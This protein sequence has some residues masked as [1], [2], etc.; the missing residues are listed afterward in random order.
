M[1]RSIRAAVTAAVMLIA[2][3]AVMAAPAGAAAPPFA[4]MDGVVRLIAPAGARAPLPAAHVVRT[5]P[6][7]SVAIDVPAARAA[8]AWSVLAGRHAPGT[9]LADVRHTWADHV[10]TDPLWSEMWGARRIRLPAAWPSSLGD[11]DVVIAVLDTGV[12]A[13]A[14]LDGALL[15]GTD[16]VDGDTDPSDAE[17]HGTVVAQV[18]AARIDNGVGGVGA[19]PACAVL[20]VRIGKKDGVWESDS[21]A[22]IVWAV[23]HGATVINM[24]YGSTGRVGLEEAAVRY[25]RSAGVTLVA[26][27]GNDGGTA[28]VYP[29]ALPGVIS[30]AATD[31]HDVVE[32][33]SQ[34]GAW[35]DVAAP[36]EA[37]TPV[38]DDT[39]LASSGT[40]FS[41]PLVAGLVALLTSAA[42]TATRAEI[43][44]AITSS[45]VPVT[46][47]G[48]IA[49]GR[50]DAAAAL[51]ALGAKVALPVGPTPGAPVVEMTAPSKALT[52]TRGTSIGLAWTETLAPA[53][54]VASRT[55]TQESTPVRGGACDESGWVAADP[56]PGEGSPFTASDLADGTCYRWRIDLTDSGGLATSTT[57]R[58]VLVDRRKPVVAAVLPKKLTRTTK[59]IVTF[60]WRIDDGDAGS[61]VAAPVRIVTQQGRVVGSSCTG[62]RTWGRSSVPPAV[63]EDEYTVGGRICVRIRLTVTD[64]AGNATTVMLPAWLRR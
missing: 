44:A 21:A 25:A 46:P 63:T 37:A 61:G 16:I 17:G 9:V 57:S 48:T 34:R 38:D 7:G 8:E 55:V 2:A 14:D 45:A 49:G 30:V 26:A 11:P 32:D 50:V 3:S 13:M 5:L 54:S 20:P 15:P 27:A 39:W 6:G 43:E 60:R 35:V 41:A 18:A 29:G 33:W 4:A 59:S 40:S 19:C 51:A 36:G 22:A 28:P 10:P 1:S 24:S 64:A 62:W 12:D 31:D 56:I 42:P 23:D 47:A 52:Y 58:P 53:A